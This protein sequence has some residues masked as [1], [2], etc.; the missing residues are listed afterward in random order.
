MKVTKKTMKQ[1]NYNVTCTSG[2]YVVIANVTIG[3]D[4][5]VLNVDGGNVTKKGEFVASFSE[6][7]N[8]LNINYNSGVTLDEKSTVLTLIEEFKTISVA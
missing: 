2:D 1:A 3:N 8:N 7:G 5:V 4:N 6:Y